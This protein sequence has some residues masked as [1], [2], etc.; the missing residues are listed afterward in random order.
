ML[1]TMYHME[2]ASGVT[3]Y[4]CLVVLRVR[5]VWGYLYVVQYLLN[6]T[7]LGY[8]EITHVVLV[9]AI[10]TVLSVCVVAR[11]GVHQVADCVALF[12]LDQASAIPVD[13]HV[14]RIACRDYDP[15]LTDCS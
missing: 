3:G 15:S 12:S 9:F 13:V 10:L 14:W 11:V 7:P 8:F 5:T 6:M 1:Q 2:F 4:R